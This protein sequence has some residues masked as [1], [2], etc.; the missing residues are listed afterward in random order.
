MK[1]S[2]HDSIS[3]VFAYH[4]IIVRRNSNVR[5]EFKMTYDS[6]KAKQ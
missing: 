6:S 4:S 3:S 2:S 1:S 5:A